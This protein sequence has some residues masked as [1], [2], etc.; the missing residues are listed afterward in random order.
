MPF[1]TTYWAKID[2]PTAKNA[3][4]NLKGDDAL[5]ITF[6]AE[7][8]DGGEG[9][10]ILDQETGGGA[11]SDTMLQIGEDTY[12]FSVEFTGTLPTLAKDGAGKFPSEYMDSTV[13]VIT[14]YDYPTPGETT[15]LVFMPDEDATAADMNAFQ[16]GAI[17]LQ[18]VDTT[19]PST[20]VCLLKGT[21]IR[22][23]TGDR[24][25]EDLR[26]GDLVLNASGAP[27]PIRYITHQSFAD[28]GIVSHDNVRPRMIPKDFFGE[29]RPYQDLYLSNNHRICLSDAL[30]ALLFGT[31]G[32]FAQ[33]KFFSETS[34]TAPLGLIEWFN[35]LLDDHAII[36]ANGQPVESLF[37]C[38]TTLKMLSTKDRRAIRLRFG[39]EIAAQIDE[40]ATH[41]PSLNSHEAAVYCHA[42]GLKP[43]RASGK[44]YLARAA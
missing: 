25:I 8:A 18:A 42:R 38:E 22:T 35:I 39:A 9:D 7:T 29:G 40:N 20:P 5:E 28:L 33:A 12:A 23:P 43:V 31:E 41:L 37:L 21:L 1:D 2:S 10:L 36:V 34:I 11:D 26:E 14:V 15:Q 6:V 32:A 30:V 16:T 17:K 13:I 27:M 4:L 19:V 24:R 44:A 3:E